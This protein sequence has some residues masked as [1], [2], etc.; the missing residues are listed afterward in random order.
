MKVP[1][2]VSAIFIVFLFGVVK[3]NAQNPM[4]VESGWGSWTAATGNYTTGG[5]VTLTATGLTPTS[6]RFN[7]TSGTGIDACTPGPT[8]GAPVIPVVA[9][10]FGNHSI[11]LGQIQTV[12]GC[13]GGCVEQLTYV[14]TPTAQDTNFIFSYAIVADDPGHSPA[15]EPFAS[16]CITAPNGDT[17]PCGFF[18]YSSGSGAPGFF[19]GSCGI[20][21]S[22]FK[23]W[24][25]SSV[26]ITNYIGQTLTVT[27]RNA[28]CALGGHFAHSYW[29]FSGNI[30]PKCCFGQ[31]T[32]LCVPTYTTSVSYGWTHN[33]TSIPGSITSC[34]SVTPQVGD[35]F[36]AYVYQPSGCLIQQTFIP[37]DT[38]FLGIEENAD[39][40][41]LKISPNPSSG[42]FT[43]ESTGSMYEAEIYD[44]LGES[45]DPSSIIHSPFSIRLDISSQSPGLYFIRIRTDRGI[46]TQKLVL[47]E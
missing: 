28:D 17:V 27:L 29:D 19:N 34:I 21:V 32:T 33:G 31:Q 8:S 41:F 1:F 12:A 26:M 9:P 18:K 16:I 11:Q 15:D 30:K 40:S 3:G 4:G 10:G 25:T 13:T 44:L 6:P 46:L 14:F 39:G 45:I 7:I 23:P 22:R 38:C 36:V 35:T 20:G 5:V 2:V 47:R 43:I 24:E 37:Q 42:K